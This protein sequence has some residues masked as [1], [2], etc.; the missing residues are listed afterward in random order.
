[1]EQKLLEKKFKTIGARVKF[2]EQRPFDRENL[3]IDVGNDNSGEFFSI[4]LGDNAPD[5]EVLDVKKSDRHLLL[6]TK[7]GRGN[8]KFLCGFDERHFFSCAIPGSV[9]TI[10]AAKQALKPLGIVNAESGIKK[11]NLHKRQKKIKAGRMYRQGEFFFTSTPEFV[12]G[13]NGVVHKK[14]PMS[15]GR[16]SKPHTAEFLVRYGGEPVRVCPMHPDGVNAE[17][18]KKI[19][20]NDKTAK[21]WKWVT[22]VRNPVVYAKGRISHSDHKTLDLKDVWHL[23]SMNTENMAAASRNVAFLD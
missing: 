5:I 20:K 11:K 14:E 9:S 23:V 21:H 4:R 10:L 22:R 12:P 3:S 8:S 6:M 2:L 19:I 15:R 1:V 13:R 18:Y 16:G 17:E 7:D